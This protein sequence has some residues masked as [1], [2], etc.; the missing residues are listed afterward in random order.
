MKD[1]ELIQSGKEI[2]LRRREVITPSQMRNDAATMIMAKVY[3][4]YGEI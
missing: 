4:F 2:S 1:E 3:M